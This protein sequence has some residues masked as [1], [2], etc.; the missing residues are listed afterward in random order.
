[1]KWTQ[2]PRRMR[3]L[4]TNTLD[5]ERSSWKPGR[6][7]WHYYW[8]VPQGSDRN[9]ASSW[10]GSK[11]CRGKLWTGHNLIPKLTWRIVKLRFAVKLNLPIVA[12]R[13]FDVSVRV[14]R[15]WIGM[16]NT[17]YNLILFDPVLTFPSPFISLLVQDLE[18]YSSTK[19]LH[20]IESFPS[21]CKAPRTSSLDGLDGLDG[22][23]GHLPLFFLIMAL[24]VTV[25]VHQVPG[26]WLYTAQRNW[27]REHLRWKVCRWKFYAPTYW[28]WNTQ[29]GQWYVKSDEKDFFLLLGFGFL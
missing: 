26:W 22:W 4:I 11:D 25:A 18:S 13:T 17:W 21:S 16:Y 7:L 27:W 19:D 2:N 1:M 23:L 24:S 10:C 6:L 3:S 8:W 28:S 15:A 14:K 12:R 20:F 5:H 9:G 29:H